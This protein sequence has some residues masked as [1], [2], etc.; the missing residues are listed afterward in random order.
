[1]SVPGAISTSSTFPER[2]S[3]A[4]AMLQSDLAGSMSE[5]RRSMSVLEL[6]PSTSARHPAP[7][8]IQS[9]SMSAGSSS[10]DASF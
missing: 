4:L 5:R 8:P 6:S 2:P 3:L 1:V 9:Q 10:T 7:R